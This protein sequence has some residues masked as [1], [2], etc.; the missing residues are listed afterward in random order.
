MT[1]TL[2]CVLLRPMNPFLRK[3]VVFLLLVFAT[4]LASETNWSMVTAAAAVA[5]D[6][7]SRLIGRHRPVLEKRPNAEALDL[8]SISF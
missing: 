5:A 1:V 4:D 7:A 2:M 6:Q 8:L 3:F